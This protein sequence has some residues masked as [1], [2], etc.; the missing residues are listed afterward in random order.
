MS[1][2][3]I[4]ALAG[5]AVI[6]AVAGAGF[7]ATPQAMAGGGSSSKVGPQGPTGPRGPQGPKGPQ[8]PQ[9]PQGPKGGVTSTTIVTATVDIPHYGNAPTRSTQH[10]WGPVTKDVHCPT[11]TIMTGGG[12]SLNDAAVNDG[13]QIV[14]TNPVTGGWHGAFTP[15]QHGTRA[16][17]PHKSEQG[18]VYAVCAIG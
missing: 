4:R 12:V 13:A 8:G 14:A 15:G 9:G 2:L 3:S 6:I 5:A 1:S 10:S 7:I 17:V 16:R 11:G 18:T